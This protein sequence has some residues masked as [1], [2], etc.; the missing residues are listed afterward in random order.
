MISFSI[1]K[2]AKEKTD[3]ERRNKLKTKKVHA[4]TK[5]RATTSEAAKTTTA[6]T[7]EAKATTTEA[8]KATTAEAA[9][10]KT[11]EAT[12]AAAK[13]AAK[14]EGVDHVIH[15]AKHAFPNPIVNSVSKDDLAANKPIPFISMS[16]ALRE[17]NWEEKIKRQTF[18]DNI[19]Y[20]YYKFTRAEAVILFNII[21]TDKDDLIDLKEYKEFS[22][23]YIMPFEACDTGK[24]HLLS[25]Q[26]FKTCFEKDP[27]RSLITFRRRHEEKKEVEEMIMNMISSKG[28]PVMNVFDYVIFRRA[29]YAW[30]KCTS[31][32]KVMTKSAFKCAITTFIQS[33]YLGKADTDEI[34]RTGIGYGQGANL[35]DLD[36]ISY[37]RVSF[38]TLA[39]V[40]FN[41][42]NPTGFLEKY[43]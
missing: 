28:R 31:S 25:L 9:K 11:T 7:E 16:D 43:R 26:D 12:G 24:D 1:S 34:F 17:L 4:A 41:E 5:A 23:L 29:L 38:Y 42:S 6:T 10:A 2:V 22:V 35:V 15:G 33:K 19:K 14:T 18:L 40:S 30:S 37:L 27:K 20:T 36:F 13:E 8:A 3:S 39:F 32:S 21:D